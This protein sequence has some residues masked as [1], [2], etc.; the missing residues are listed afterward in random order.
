MIVVWTEW[1]D[2]VAYALCA[3]GSAGLGERGVDWF[4]AR[5]IWL[6]RDTPTRD[7]NVVALR[8]ALRH[9][10]VI[11]G[12]RLSCA[13]CYCHAPLPFEQTQSDC[14]EWSG[15]VMH[16]DARASF[17]TWPP[18]LPLGENDGESGSRPSF[19]PNPPSFDDPSA[20]RRVHGQNGYL[21]DPASSH[22]LVSKIKPCMSKYKLI[23]R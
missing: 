9:L 10:V 2:R 13:V 18:P 8:R 19:G 3:S 22:M 7:S 20:E 5:R 11:S 14:G 15:D 16:G 12:G 21:V 6:L 4:A 17:G 23:L 1:T